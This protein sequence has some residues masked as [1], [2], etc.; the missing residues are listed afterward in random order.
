MFD[1]VYEAELE[2]RGEDFQI[3]DFMDTIL[4]TGPIPI[5]EF[6]A[7]FKDNFPLK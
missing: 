7:V 3:L 5:D 4:Q 1:E 2:R 6:P